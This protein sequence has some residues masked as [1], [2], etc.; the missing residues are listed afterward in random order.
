MDIFLEKK[1]IAIETI[2]EDMCRSMHECFFFSRRFG[3][4][5]ES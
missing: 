3:V 5:G 2:I 4:F 1:H